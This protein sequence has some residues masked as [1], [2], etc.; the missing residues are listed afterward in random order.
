MGFLFGERKVSVVHTEKV[1]NGFIISASGSRNY[2][3]D[4]LSQVHIAKDIKEA[5]E[6]I[7]KALEEI[8]KE[9]D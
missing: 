5:S 9:D 1:A 4:R 2:D 7:V 6:L 8:G 3:E